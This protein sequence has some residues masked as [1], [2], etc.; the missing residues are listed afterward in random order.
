MAS[1]KKKVAGT[2]RFIS[3]SSRMC[4]TLFLGHMVEIRIGN[5]NYQKQNGGKNNGQIIQG[6][7][8]QPE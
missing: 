8:T 6:R 5:C 7:E 4:G 3:E 1:E 2:V